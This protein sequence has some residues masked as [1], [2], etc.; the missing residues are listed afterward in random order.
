MSTEVSNESCSYD[1]AV[2]IKT[3]EK[4][5]TTTSDGKDKNCTESSHV[6]HYVWVD[7]Q[8]VFVEDRLQDVA[9]NVQV[10]IHQIQTRNEKDV[11]SFQGVNNLAVRTA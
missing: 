11:G 5:C 6:A 7:D 4:T 1:S 9:W 2:E 8:E 3:T 10:R